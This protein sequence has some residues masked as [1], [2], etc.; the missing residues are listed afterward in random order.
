MPKTLILIHGKK[1]NFEWIN[2]KLNYKQKIP[3][4]PRRSVSSLVKSVSVFQVFIGVVVIWFNILFN[5]KHFLDQTF[6]M[7][8]VWLSYVCNIKFTLFGDE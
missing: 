3:L 4:W 6:S 1:K 7:A 2:L 5:W 8:I